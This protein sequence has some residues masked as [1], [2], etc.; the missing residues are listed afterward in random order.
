MKVARTYRHFLFLLGFFFFPATYIQAQNPLDDSITTRLDSTKV[1]QLKDSVFSVTD[2][3]LEL[4]K[5][6]QKLHEIDNSRLRGDTIVNVI[7]EFSTFSASVSQLEETLKGENLSTFNLNQLKN[8]RNKLIRFNSRLEA[9]QEDVNRKTESLVLQKKALSEILRSFSFQNLALED[10][11]LLP[12]FRDRVDQILYEDSILNARVLVNLKQ[13]VTIQNQ[14]AEQKIII[15]NQ[16]DDIDFYT[17]NYQLNLFKRDTPPL[18]NSV[19]AGSE[20][21]FTGRL[22]QQFLTGKNVL[23]E[24]LRENKTGIYLQ[25]ILFFTLL[26]ILYSIKKRATQLSENHQ[27][28]NLSKILYVLQHPWGSALL[29]TLIFGPLLYTHPPSLLV[30][31]FFILM[32][33][34]LLVIVE[35]R[36]DRRELVSAMLL[37]LAYT[38][39]EIES[40]L[41]GNSFPQRIL[42]IIASLLAL[43]CIINFIRH[44]NVNKDAYPRFFHRILLAFII[45]FSVAILS[46]VLGYSS[47]ASMLNLAT[48][49]SLIFGIL[50]F[51]S[52]RIIAVLILL[53]TYSQR[54]QRSKMIRENQ[55]EI[56]ANL[57][58]VASVLLT[59][60]WI[61]LSLDSFNLYDMLYE[62]I[63]TFL[64]A[65]R[66]LGSIEFSYWSIIVFI[67]V[68]WAS[69]TLS[70]LIKYFLEQR[71]MA[72]SSNTKHKKGAFIL[73]TRYFILLLGFFLA[74][75]AAGIP[76][77]KITIILGALSV[78]IGFG[79]QNIVNNLVSGF[80]LALE[81]P[82][83]VGD[84][85]EVG[86]FMGIVQ[87]IGIRSS[88]IKTFDGSE[89]IVPN[90]NFI[91]GEVTNWT[92]SDKHY[93]IEILVGVAYGSDSSHVMEVLKQ[94]LDN[95]DEIMKTPEPMVIFQ[96]FGESSLDFR[97]LFWCKNRDIWVSL[98]S[99]VMDA[100]YKR[101]KQEQIEIPFPQRDLHIK[102]DVSH[103]NGHP[104]LT[105]PNNLKKVSPKKVK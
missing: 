18:W 71:Y 14:L 12:L 17:L 36:N 41:I 53:F 83:Q 23:K 21:N 25:I 56:S 103:S 37:S 70:R 49:Q 94:T 34:P 42:L 62:T 74:I 47:L 87:D 51:F 9:W 11:S 35:G 99:E 61:S 39:T 10:T 30:Q 59:L 97:V 45:V 88:T 44:S 60:Y 77:D 16:L 48:T 102:S 86:T 66:S 58:Q 33:I 57:S 3:T 8:T 19:S 15:N 101:F 54:V 63:T 46:N 91:S 96:G 81:R 27:G 76:I 43:S 68:I 13:L 4:E 64:L 32:L 80:I 50:L 79:L 55:K 93:R 75:V 100:I 5:A 2:L 72:S 24:Y 26:L 1:N 98:R 6:S 22:S 7:P 73:L 84:V 104:V 40:L 31:I 89:V 38:L 65:T 78:G 69:V 92:L 105:N 95:H 20:K 29:I 90:A 28:P 82:I 67:L 52:F 85:I